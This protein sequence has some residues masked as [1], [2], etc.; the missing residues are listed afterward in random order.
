VDVT[1]GPVNGY[2]LC[3][4]IK[5]ELPSTRV[6]LLSSKQNPYDTGR[7]AAA[8]ADDHID[9]PFDTQALIEK[10][11]VLST[12]PAR[13]AEAARPLR[14][15]PPKPAEAPVA[16][17]PIARI[18]PQQ[19]PAPALGS[20][21][22]SSQTPPPKPQ[23]GPVHDRTE[24]DRPTAI[25]SPI[26]NVSGQASSLELKLNGLGLT[27]VQVEAVLALSKEIVEQAVWEIVPALAETLIK[28][29]IQRLTR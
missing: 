14:A 13:V 4:Q 10:V 5:S 17:T 23:S 29:E 12:A 11:K 25:A 20:K 27:R 2:D 16:P 6:L 18:E 3:Q 22:R 1:L 26:L 15:P 19:A 21:P 28:E 9:K 8:G 24:V 7:G